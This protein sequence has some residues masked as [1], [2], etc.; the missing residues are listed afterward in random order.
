MRCIAEKLYGIPPEQVVGSSNKARLES[1]PGGPALFK[2]PEL[3]SFDDRD[4]KV[5]W[6][7]RAGLFDARHPDAPV[8]ERRPRRP[9]VPPPASR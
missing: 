4:E 6:Q 7:D 3:R 9:P 8:H 1:G 5:V 2:L